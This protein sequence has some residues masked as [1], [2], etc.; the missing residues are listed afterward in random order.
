M[1]DIATPDH[2]GKMEQPESPRKAYQRPFLTTYGSVRQ[3][4]QSGS[5]IATE[6]ASGM[7]MA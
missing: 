3:M 4:T 5:G 7:A 6:G 1:R 2:Q